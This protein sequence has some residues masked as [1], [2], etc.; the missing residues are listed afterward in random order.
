MHSDSLKILLNNLTREVEALWS[1]TNYRTDSYSVR[2][3]EVRTEVEAGAT[4]LPKTK[5]PVRGTMGVRVVTQQKRKDDREVADEM[6]S[7]AMLDAPG[8]LTESERQR[9]QEIRERIEGCLSEL[10]DEFA[11]IPNL[12][13]RIFESQ[14]YK[15]FD[16]HDLA[17]HLT[18][19]KDP[20]YHKVTNV[21][22][23]A[24][25]LAE[26]LM[27][28]GFDPKLK[29]PFPEWE[30]VIV[31][32]TE[33]ILSLA[34]REFNSYDVFILVNAPLIDEELPV[35]LA[36]FSVDDTEVEVSIGYASDTLLERLNASGREAELSGI[37]TAITFRCEMSVSALVDSY[38]QVYVLGARVAE[39][40][41][42]CLRLIR[43]EDIGVLALEVFPSEGF[44]PAI[45]KTYEQHYQPELALVL[46]KRFWFEVQSGA[47]LDNIE[48]EQLRSLLCSYSEV[49]LVKGLAVALRRFR[50]SCERYSPSDPERLLDIAFAF[51]AVFLNDG[52][53]KELSY[54][55][56]LRVAR[57]LGNT[58]EKRVEIFDAIRNLY[59]FRSKIAHGETLDKMKQSDAEKLKL[60]LDRAPRIL[61]EALRVIV[62]GNG[63][64]GLK[65]TDGLSKW[66]KR[67]ELG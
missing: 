7:S 1:V 16:R 2:R 25:I 28:A 58:V 35:R 54:R 13:E 62:L 48:I 52:E 59:N 56:C 6:L 22:F 3:D 63:P 42:D 46:P 51:E 5:R 31:R 24:D 66:W 29:S 18:E 8:W 34:A 64:K 43:N 32:A 44:S 10:F 14:G 36:R 50:S 41:V 21:L 30:P 47:P 45:R 55:L 65:S 67:I 61:T 15:H 27:T 40:V 38:L 23:V 19:E 57:F 12:N 20:H 37:N 39:R 11:R 4:V 60:V 49:D 53:N 26:E 17:R 33:R 9:Q